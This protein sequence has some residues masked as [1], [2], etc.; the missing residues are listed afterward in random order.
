MPLC[1]DLN[2]INHLGSCFPMYFSFIK[3]CIVLLSI[4]LGIQGIYALITNRYAASCLESDDNGAP[5]VR[6]CDFTYATEISLLNK[7]L[8]RPL[9]KAEA[10][11]DLA[12]VVVMIIA[13]QFHRINMRKIVAQVDQD[14]LSPPDYTIMVR[15][16]PSDV[17]DEELIKY[18]EHIIPNRKTPVAHINR[19]YDVAMQ[20]REARKITGLTGKMKKAKT[21]EEKDAI[22]TQ[23]KEIQRKLEEADEEG[24]ELAPVAFVSFEKEQDARDVEYFLMGPP[25]KRFLGSI[26]SYPK[27]LFKERLHG[28][29]TPVVEA[30]EPSDIL[31]ENLTYSNRVKMRSRAVTFFMTAVLVAGCFGALI[32]IS[33]G[34]VISLSFWLIFR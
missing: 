13:F 20:I 34:Q 11:L 7:V 10:W 14:T 8:D 17:T 23:I 3:F 1:G 6:D 21:Q 2:Q 29:F 16:I 9:L 12:V 18:F 31:W 19:S 22:L 25:L 33:V 5:I 30:P 27:T 26:L 4:M 24:V 32:G 28:K 15:R